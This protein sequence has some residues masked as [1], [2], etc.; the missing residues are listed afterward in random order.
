M[1]YIIKP[2]KYNLET[3]ELLENPSVEGS[4]CFV[5]SKTNEDLEAF[6]KSLKKIRLIFPQSLGYQ[7]TFLNNPV[8]EVKPKIEVSTSSLKKDALI[9]S[10][11]IISGIIGLNYGTS[12]GSYILRGSFNALKGAVFGY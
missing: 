3:H 10:A 9:F 2:Y 1:T 8:I 7:P 4:S 12:I 6:D 11:G 5:S